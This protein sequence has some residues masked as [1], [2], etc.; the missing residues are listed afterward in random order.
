MCRV[1]SER[2]C[3]AHGWSQPKVDTLSDR[4]QEKRQDTEHLC[5][6]VSHIGGPL[7]EAQRRRDHNGL[8]SQK[9]LLLRHARGKNSERGTA[10]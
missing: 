8:A 7:Y 1:S 2:T 9:L 5:G 6:K 10:V 3:H 4:R